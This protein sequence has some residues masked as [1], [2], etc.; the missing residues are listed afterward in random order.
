MVLSTYE[1]QRIV[2]YHQNGLAPSQILSA[3][4]VENIVTTRQT[5]AR[6]IRRFINTRSIFHKKG[7]GRPSKITNRVLELVER[8]MR[9]DDETTAV[10]VHTLLTSCGISISLPTI[11]RSHAE[12][13]WTFRGSK[14]CLLIRHVNHEKRFQFVY[15]NYLEH[16]NNGLENV[17]WSDET[18]VQLES[19]RRH[20]YRKRG[21]QPTLKPRP[22]HPIKV[23]VWAGISRRGTTPV[24][25]FEG[26]MNAELYVDILRS[27][28]L[29]FIRTTYPNSHRFMQD[30]DPKH[31][32]ATARRFFDQEGINWW[33]TPPE[34]PDAN[35]MENLWHELK[36]YIRR[37]IK[38]TRKAELISGIKEFWDTVDVDKCIDHLRKVFPRIMELDGAATGY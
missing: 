33:R 2:F 4:K 19:H 11:L 7:S 1:K 35:P 13:G 18:T 3:L 37:E 22:K 32:S 17:I 30:N 10:Q 8:R 20:S 14:Y 6:F 38:S 26:I 24:V 16:L 29:P 28:L 9:E 25:I 23:H 12:L 21:E 15:N 31:T 36:E 5:I 34:S 27:S